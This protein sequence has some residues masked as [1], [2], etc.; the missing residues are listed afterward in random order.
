VRK[1][2]IIKEKSAT[3]KQ[4]LNLRNVLKA[5]ESKEGKQKATFFFW[6]P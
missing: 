5:D 6:S 2:F 3:D 1:I 4:T